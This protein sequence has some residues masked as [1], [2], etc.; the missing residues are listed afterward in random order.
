MWARGAGTAFEYGSEVWRASISHRFDDN[1][2]VVCFVAGT[3]LY[4]MLRCED[5]L[6]LLYVDG[7]KYG[8]A[9]QRARLAT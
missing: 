7:Y 2:F 3:E 9:T 6:F 5:D 4:H 1:V 8:V